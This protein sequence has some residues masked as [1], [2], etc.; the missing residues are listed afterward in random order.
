MSS[1]LRKPT[2][3]TFEEYIAFEETATVRHELIDGTLF[4][5]VGGS[6]AHE[7]I[8]G[9][10]FLRIA[11]HLA[12][13]CQ[14]FQSGMRL[15]VEHAHDSDGYYPDILVSCDPAD[16]ERMFR[17][18]PILLIEVLSPSTERPDRGEKKLNYLQIPSLQE[19]LLVA[20]DKPN[21]EIMRR[22]TSWAVE[23]L[24]PDDTLNMESV[25]LSLSL[26]D[27]YNTIRF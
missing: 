11:G 3:V 8:T 2:R 16:R 27:I 23:E 21:V 24:Y 22:R 7:L 15:K 9:R 20:Q 25:G 10:L 13:R 17:R 6:D 1:V 14:V 19:Y 4:A 26:S 12:D 18:S 5:M